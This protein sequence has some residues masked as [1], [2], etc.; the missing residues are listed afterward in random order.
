MG[1]L[2]L[3]LAVLVAII[4]L[5]GA[6]F[7]AQ[8]E[9]PPAAPGE[10]TPKFLF[11]GVQIV[12]Q[13]V[14]KTCAEGDRCIVVDTHCGFCCQYEAINA[15]FEDDYNQSFDRHCRRYNEGYCECFDLSSYPS[16]IEG[17]C[18]LVA[19]PEDTGG[20]TPEMPP[21]AQRSLPPEPS[22]EDEGLDAPL[23]APLDAPFTNPAQ[24]P[25]G[26]GRNDSLFAPLPEQLPPND[27]FDDSYRNENSTNPLDKPLP[28]GK[29]H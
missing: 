5:G 19:W 14:Y 29:L 22:L 7:Y 28:A 2:F 9:N 16:C 17:K 4:I 12:V 1:N 13:D 20:R 6:I 18:Q 27:N 25:P 21:P 26:D 15:R 23:E 11:S 8:K 24:P 10:E 3:K